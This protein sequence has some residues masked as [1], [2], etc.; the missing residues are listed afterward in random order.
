MNGGFQPNKIVLS[1]RSINPTIALLMV[2]LGDHFF[3][4]CL[5][6]GD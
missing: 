6:I 1:L 4:A 3:Y 5:E 2:H